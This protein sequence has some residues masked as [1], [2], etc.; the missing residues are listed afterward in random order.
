[1]KR[2]SK[3]PTPPTPTNSSPDE[4]TIILPSMTELEEAKAL[5]RKQYEQWKKPEE[6]P[7]EEIEASYL[8]HMRQWVMKYRASSQVKHSGIG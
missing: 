4:P 1:M 5:W 2:T 7:W 6:P 8:D 3:D